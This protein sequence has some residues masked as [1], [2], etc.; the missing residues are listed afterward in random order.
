MSSH[1]VLQHLF[2][3]WK[4]YQ[5]LSLDEQDAIEI[6]VMEILDSRRKERERDFR[7]NETDGDVG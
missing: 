1:H 4:W 6:A 7:I 2:A 5:S 3:A